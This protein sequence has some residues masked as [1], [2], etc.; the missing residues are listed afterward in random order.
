MA[1][2]RPASCALLL[3]LC[4]VQGDALALPSNAPASALRC[5]ARPGRAPALYLSAASASP[6]PAD[7]DAAARAEAG[8]TAT[9]ARPPMSGIG[10]PLPRFSWRTVAF[11]TLNPAV[12]L[13]LPL[14]ALLL[15]IDLLGSSFGLSGAT[16]VSG[17]LWATPLFLLSVLPL[18][19][20]PALSALSE[21]SQ[22]SETICLYAL[23]HRL[24][25]L[26]ALLAASV[27]SASAA[28]CEELAFRGVLQTIAVGVLGALGLTAR[29]SA[30]VAVVAQALLFGLL[31]AY[32]PSA[33]YVIAASLAGAAFG[34]AF[35]CTSNLAV[36]VVMHFALD[37]VS[38]GVCH[39]QVTRGG[40][41]AQ[42]KLLA[43]DYPIARALKDMASWAKA[44]D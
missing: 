26:R 15:R 24:V 28:V 39:I 38:F 23:G 18:E 35:A 16:F 36:P 37:L 2:Q 41:A 40:E 6:A 8:L 21:V 42:H 25:P 3:F 1:R 33:V 44:V 17:L 7:D 19:R 11:I 32:T 43:A 31:H 34:A 29:A 5:R 27:L 14:V 12:L 4:P 20:I 10:A 30:A 9:T 22:A 13:P